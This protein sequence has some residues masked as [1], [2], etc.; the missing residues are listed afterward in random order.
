MRGAPETGHVSQPPISRRGPVRIRRVRSPGARERG[1]QD[2]VS[3][4]LKT[5]LPVNLSSA[6]D[7]SFEVRYAVFA[8]SPS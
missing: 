5:H 6:M 3:E 1:L 7:T 2:P 8:R 4:R